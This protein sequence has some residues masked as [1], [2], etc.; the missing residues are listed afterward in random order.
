MTVCWKEAPFYSSSFCHSIVTKTASIPTT[1]CGVSKMAFPLM[2]LGL[3]NI[4]GEQRSGAALHACSLQ[5]KFE[6]QVVS[7]S[8]WIP[9]CFTRPAVPQWDS[10]RCVNVCVV[11]RR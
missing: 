9:I 5:R 7:L 2:L 8:K 6:K 10:R 1:M 3:T 11:R 4:T